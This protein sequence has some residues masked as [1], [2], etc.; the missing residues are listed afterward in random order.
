MANASNTNAP[1][2]FI[3]TK[4]EKYAYRSSNLF[5]VRDSKPP[6]LLRDASDMCCTKSVANSK[7]LRG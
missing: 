1:T 3:E 6:S 5:P 4:L 7:H 2:R